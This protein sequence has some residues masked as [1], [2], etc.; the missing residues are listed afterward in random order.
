MA[1]THFIWTF[2]GRKTNVRLNHLHERALRVV[3]NDDIC[4]FEE[5]LGKDKSETM[6]QRNIKILAAELFKIENN[7]LNDNMA[8]LICKRNSVDYKLRSKQVFC[9]YR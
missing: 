3:Y 6:H 2:C 5:P 4:L 9:Y 8:Q 1:I 7:L